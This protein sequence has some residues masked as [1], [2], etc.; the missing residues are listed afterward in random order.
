MLAPTVLTKCGARMN[1]SV[2]FAASSL[3]QKK[4]AALGFE[5]AFRGGTALSAQCAHWAAPPEGEP[6]GGKSE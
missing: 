6:R 4:L 2:G 5:S 3:R 1:L